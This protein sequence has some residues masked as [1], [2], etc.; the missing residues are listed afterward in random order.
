MNQCP[1]RRRSDL[2]PA[3][4][5]LE[6]RALL[7]VA[8]QLININ[9]VLGESSFPAQL[10]DVNGTLFFSAF[11][12]G[13]KRELWKSDGTPQGTVLV[14]D[15]STEPSNPSG[16]LPFELTNVNGT[17]FFVANDDIHG[18]ELWKSDGTPG[19]TSM[20]RD[21]T[22]GPAGN[23]SQISELTAVG[24]KLYF[25]AI[26]E[27]GV[28]L[29][30]SDGT[31]LGTSRVSDI[32]R[33]SVNPSGGENSVP[34]S[35]TNVNGTLFFVAT[36]RITGLELYKL[37]PVT[38]VV[39]QLKDIAP[40]E[41]ES[42]PSQLTNVNGTLYFT[43]VDADHSRELWK[44][45]GTPQGTVLVKDIGPQFIP[46][47][48]IPRSSEPTG[49]V[50]FN[51][52]LFFS[53]NAGPTEFDASSGHELWKSDGTEAG[54]VQVADL[55]VGFVSVGPRLLTAVGNTLFFVTTDGEL[56]EELY[57][58]DGTTAGTVMVKDIF[59]GVG[60]GFTTIRDENQFTV[61]VNDKLYFNVGEGR[62][63]VALW[64]SDGTP[65]G[66]FLVSDVESDP[67]GFGPQQLTRVNNKLF[68]TADDGTN[69]N[70]LW[71]L[72]TSLPDPAVSA[73]LVGGKVLI[74]APSGVALD[75]LV[76][77]D[78]G[79]QEV[80]VAS[81]M[82]GVATTEFRFPMASVTVGLEATLGPLG[83][84]F[85][86][87]A[88]NLPVTVF[89]G[90]GNDS[91]T[92]GAGSDLLGGDDGQDSL[93][94]GAGSDQLMGGNGN[95][96]I[97]S[98][99]GFDL[100]DGGDGT[101]DI[102]ME[103]TTTNLALSSAQL[104]IGLGDG[105]E[106]DDHIN[107]EKAILLGGGAANVMT[108]S[109]AD[110]P[111]SLFGG[112]GNDVLIG[113][114]QADYVDGQGGNDT[115]SARDGNDTLNGAAGIDVFR[116]VAYSDFVPGEI[117]NL[118]LTNSSF[119][120]KVGPGT[121]SADSL[122][123]FEV[124]DITG[125]GMRDL[126]N[127]SGF[128]NTGVTTING[129]GGNDVIV[130]T[131]GADMIFTLTG[132]DSILGGGGSDSVFSGSGND[133]ISGGAG[134]DNLNG[135][136]GN[137]SIVGDADNDILIGGAGQD[138]LSGNAGNDFLSGQD[139]FNQLF[140]GD[141]NDTLQGGSTR[142]LLFG[143]V[144]DDRLFG[145]QGNDDLDGGDGADSLIGAVGDDSL[146]GGTGADT[147]QGDLGSDTLDGGADF[148]RINEV[149]DTNLTIVGSTLSTPSFGTDSVVAVERIQ[150]SGGA[151]NNFFDARQATVAVF[152]A[153]AA[154]NDT[155]LGGSKADGITG[156]DG[157]DVL[158]GGAGGDVLDGGAGTDYIIE[159]ANVDF[160]VNGVTITSS[161]TGMDTP[162]TIERIVLIGGAGANKLD[163][164]LASIPVILLGAAGNDTLL[165]GSG[166][167]SLSG[168]SRNDSTVAGSD[169]VDSLN[170]GAGSDVLEND[171]ADTKVT[172][173]G[174][175]LVFD[176]FSLVPAWVDAI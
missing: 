92:T 49:L 2:R 67:L 170:G 95:D 96:T 130:G 6:D 23:I 24:N 22:P 71:V 74:N 142:D 66:T 121:L 62:N 58:T 105:S 118:T 169:G 29:W 15:I 150:V 47:S 112:G 113:S 145:L 99:A 94:S 141:G 75:L 37:D 124:A 106:V 19:G 8:T 70:E 14:K 155:L 166:A 53:A 57:K 42:G 157:D 12:E 176:F 4:E 80:V 164:S 73:S 158:S 5:W 30:V 148:D 21:I 84:R 110:I 173:A 91:L 44:S 146:T 172:G 163:A 68:F 87:S 162:T 167:D 109:N 132:A 175:T 10:V 123:G 78:G 140:G 69:G 25:S 104:T 61:A 128:T 165:G 89:G 108:A 102:L 138:I 88:V 100:L 125:G 27:F 52:T 161:A 46:F 139:G 11:T 33:E 107:F 28:E 90:S 81:R 18:F 101:A 119:L 168:G 31:E 56:N 83:D 43:A 41:F 120:V 16:S 131:A 114:N 34:Q 151:A 122:L 39:S 59:G 9:S 160:T 143:E 54:T 127:A 79:T 159:K 50:N 32:A 152:L 98:G 133:T 134:A 55:S 174:D 72:D 17:L 129:G 116:D 153:G 48:T 76:T 60:S 77:L 117:R 144:G 135:Q 26:D 82:S 63:G 86:S 137:D 35:L 65:D 154:G 40:N 64:R 171:A 1:T 13:T 85:D 111:V 20:V 97:T 115:L 149:F 45:D 51:G 7:S 36:D 136:N 126:F 147:L 3:V 103:S 156:G 93:V 38:G